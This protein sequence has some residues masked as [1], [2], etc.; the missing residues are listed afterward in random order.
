MDQLAVEVSIYI[1]LQLKTTGSGALSA[2]V[3]E[4]A[5]SQFAFSPL[6]SGFGP[7]GAFSCG[8]DFGRTAKRFE[9]NPETRCF[10]RLC[11]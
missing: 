1:L 2:A 3:R 11:N 4:V 10:Q 5:R 7:A 6:S 8:L 9:R